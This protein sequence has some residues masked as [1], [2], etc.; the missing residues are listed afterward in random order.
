MKELEADVS[1]IDDL[2]NA[3]MEAEAKWAKL[4]ALCASQTG[5]LS[6]WHNKG[7]RLEAQL[8]KYRKALENIEYNCDCSTGRSIARDALKE[9][10]NDR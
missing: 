3:K 5:L 2:T 4:E 10:D 6:V 1:Y 9:A 7:D 8:A